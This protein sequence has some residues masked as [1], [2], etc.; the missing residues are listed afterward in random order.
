MRELMASL[1]CPECLHNIE[2]PER[3]IALD[4][5]VECDR[6][7]HDLGRWWALK[8]AAVPTTSDKPI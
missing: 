3:G 4:K 6:C 1:I 7:G 5:H 8:N 2:L